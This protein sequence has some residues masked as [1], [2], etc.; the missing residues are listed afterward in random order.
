MTVTDARY[1]RARELTLGFYPPVRDRSARS[2]TTT[3]G[4]RVDR[5]ASGIDDRPESTIHTATS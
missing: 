3:S 2:T 1:R 4:Q 5:A